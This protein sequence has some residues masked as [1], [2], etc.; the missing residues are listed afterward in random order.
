MEN[1]PVTNSQQFMEGSQNVA[2]AQ[3]T[4]GE[5]GANME[6]IRAALGYVANPDAHNTGVME[7]SADE[8]ARRDVQRVIDLGAV[9][10]TN[11]AR[12]AKSGMS[13]EQLR[14]S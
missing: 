5:Q 13:R 2:Q 9:E 8:L 3:P 1:S 10:R 4:H 14:R 11:L 12:L 7:L 6:D